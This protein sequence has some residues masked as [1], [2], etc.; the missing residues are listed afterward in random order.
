MSLI[1]LFSFRST[2][3][4]ANGEFVVPV[5]STWGPQGLAYASIA[6]GHAKLVPGPWRGHYGTAVIKYS[7]LCT[8]ADVTI[9][10]QVITGNAGTAADWETQ[11]STFT[12]TA[13]GAAQLR[14]FT[15]G[16]VDWRV[17]ATTAGVVTALTIWGT[18]YRTSDRGA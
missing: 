5:D 7:A 11:G 15:P 1:L 3:I 2:A 17:R 4:P 6:T 9:A 18:V 12:V 13:G 8:G 16:T 10:D 14:E